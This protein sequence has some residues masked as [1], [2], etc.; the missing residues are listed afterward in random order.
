M[1]VEGDD[2]EKLNW[3][4]CS[5][6]VTGGTGSFGRTFIEHIL[7]K[8]PRR[9]V[10][11]SRD[12]LKQHEMRRALPDGPDSPLRY[13]IGDV[14]DPDR[15]RRA[16]HEV[17]VVIHA[18]ALKQVPACEYNPIE[19]V[20]TNILGARNIIEAAIDTGV[21]R[22]IG[23]STDKAVSPVNMYGATKL[24]AEK[25]FVQGNSYVGA[26]RTRFSC[27]R[28]GN[29]VGSRGS[30]V[31]L[32]LDQRETGTVTVTDSR[33]TRFWI[34]LDQGVDFVVRCTEQMQGGEVFVP[35]IPSMR[36]VDLAKALAPGCDV[37]VTGIRAGEKLH[38][39]LI[40]EDEARNTLEFGDMFVLQPI[41]PWWAGER[42]QDGR[43]L[44]DGFRYSSDGNDRWLSTA[45]LQNMVA[46]A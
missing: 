15:L 42:W 46:H 13:F 1:D 8:K 34:T 45:E 17:D 4:E 44:P 31:P 39:L 27:V 10:V 30:V 21:K 37:R 35:K 38:E 22:V 29:V 24:V 11:F 6:L 2:L 32:F 9:V 23:M 3:S 14:R 18:A 12:E 33:M 43:P 25:L 41:F 40:S 7:T 16:F 19:A 26:G 28:Y 36:I 20:N 5:L